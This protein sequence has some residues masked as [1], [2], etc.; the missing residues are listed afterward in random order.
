MLAARRQPLGAVLAQRLEQGVARPPTDDASDDQR[1]AD[2]I[3]EQRRHLRAVDAVARAYRLRVVERA[4][5]R[6]HRQPL[7]QPSLRLAELL[8]RP[9]DRGAQGRVAGG[10]AAARH[11]QQAEPLVEPR[12][13][14]GRRHRARAAGRELDRQRQAVQPPAQLADC[15]EVD[16][17]V[18][19]PRAV[20]EQVDGAA[21]L[22]AAEAQH[23]LAVD[24]QRGA[25]GGEDV[26]VGAAGE[27]LLDG[28]GRAVDHVLA[29][30]EHEEAAV[31]VAQHVGDRAG[32]VGVVR[33]RRQLAPP[34]IR[35]PAG[36]LER[37]PRLARAAGAGDR[38]QR[39]LGGE[40]LGVREVLLAPEEAARALRQPP[41]D[42][43]RALRASG[44]AGGSRAR[45]RACR[46]RARARAPRGRRRAP[47]ARPGRRPGAR[48]GTGRAPAPE[49]APRAAARPPPGAAARAAPPRGG[50]ARPAPA[51]GPRRRAPAA[52]RGAGSRPAR[53]R[54]T[55]GR[56]TACRA[57]GRARSRTGSARRTAPASSRR[58]PA[59]RGGRRP[60]APDRR[61]A[62][63]RG[64]RGPAGWTA[65]RPGAPAPGTR[66]GSRAARRV[67]VSRP[68]GRHRAMRPRAG[69]RRRPRG[70][71]PAGAVR[72][73]LSP[74]HRT[75]PRPCRCG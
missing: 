15:G 46:C 58:A 35:A 40:P 62:G 36:Q 11:R 3:V 10:R 8:V 55:R 47:A 22:E 26:Q 33:H 32:D 9:V 53:T 68:A 67:S 60:P 72:G 61:P 54:R 5:A 59:A 75:A 38:H 43:R 21:R 37:Q 41:D 24:A 64:R 74:S 27:Q 29:V 14:L 71:A 56:R 17:S 4:V 66:A 28:A 13:D 2:Q 48:S 19:R 30:V 73:S 31:A 12:D 63:S 42:R 44:R 16:D 18:R 65:G 23:L 49:R 39:R 7:E 20:D 34:R 57:T 69:R 25:A 1:V 50:P 45:A 51:R 70:P 6:E 52:P